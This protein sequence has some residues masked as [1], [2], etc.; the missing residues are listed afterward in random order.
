VRAHGPVALAKGKHWI[1]L[2]REDLWVF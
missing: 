1:E 2:P